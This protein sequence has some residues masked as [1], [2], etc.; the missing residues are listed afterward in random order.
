MGRDDGKAALHLGE[1]FVAKEMDKWASNHEIKEAYPRLGDYISHT[2]R[3][4]KVAN[5]KATKEADV[6]DGKMG[7]I[8]IID[9]INGDREGK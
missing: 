2:L 4:W 5:K 6:A 8:D 1:G 9:E 7:Q 3:E